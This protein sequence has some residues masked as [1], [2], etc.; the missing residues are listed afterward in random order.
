MNPVSIHQSVKLLSQV[1]D[2]SFFADD[3][4]LTAG[5]LNRLIQHLDYQDRATRAWLIGA[6]LLCGLTHEVEGA[7]LA[8]EPGC[9]LT[10][11]GDLLTIAA[12]LRFTHS[13]PFKDE[14]A[15]YQPLGKLAP[16]TE[17][18]TTKA[19]A[20]DSSA[21][22]LTAAALKNKVVALYLE[23]YAKEPEFC[24]G[25]NC[26]NK[27]PVQ[28]NNLRVLLLPKTITTLP[29]GLPEIAEALPKIEAARPKLTTGI[30]KLEGA[31]G[32]QAAFTSAISVTRSS[33]VE[34]LAPLTAN[35]SF[36]EAL[37]EAGFDKPLDWN[38]KLPGKTL[39]PAAE[40]TGLLHIHGFYREF[41]HAYNEWRDSLYCLRGVCA[42]DPEAFPK[43]VLLGVTGRTGRC[44]RDLFRH[45][46][47]RASTL[48]PC[49]DGLERARL[50][51]RR[52]MGLIDHFKQ[53]PVAPQIRF[54]PSAGC[55]RPLGE[56]ALPFYFG[57]KFT[58]PWN[59]EA[60]LRCAP[61]EPSSYHHNPHAAF[62]SDISCR[63]FY[64][65][66]GHLGR[67]LA[68]VETELK[69]LRG[70]FNLAFQ[71][72]SI[73]IE[74]DP[75]L[76]VRPPIRFLDIESLFHHHTLDL[77]L[78]LKDA[79]SFTEVIS[80]EA[81]K[82]PETSVSKEKAAA[83]SNA[84]G[85]LKLSIASTREKLPGT[86]AEFSKQANVTNFNLAITDTAQ[87]GV[88]VN[89]LAYDFAKYSPVT[90]TDRL[91]RPE[92]LSQFG[93][94]FDLL[95]NR[96]LKV[97][98]RSIFQ[99]FIEAN[100]GAEHL[101]GVPAGGT[102]VLVYSA[103]S[104]AN[105]R[106]VKA[107]FCLPYFSY[108]DLTTLEEEEPPADITIKPPPYVF[109]PKPWKDLFPWTFTPLTDIYV[110][111]KFGDLENFVVQSQVNLT[112]NLD[113]LINT[114]IVNGILPM[115]DVFKGTVPKADLGLVGNDFYRDVVNMIELNNLE[116]ERLHKEVDL[117]LATN[118]T[119]NRINELDVQKAELLGRATIMVADNM[120]KAQAS[121]QPV[122]S[123]ERAM[124]NVIKTNAVSLESD[125]ARETFKSGAAKAVDHH[126]D[127]A[128]VNTNFSS[129]VR[130][131]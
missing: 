81:G 128:A 86:F 121:G 87:K 28:H 5:Q 29:A 13:R 32:L 6:G 91:V 30:K 120:A 102:F 103:S 25:D 93:H 105:K 4:V 33:L 84:S 117:G 118:V 108:F 31:N 56:R 100:P 78:R 50:L 17:L 66:E 54:T 69:R 24:T 125:K 71:I 18:L 39:N 65:I 96:E 10:T 104:E 35:Q 21:K 46:F 76:V 109:E 80:R 113:S 114:K 79:E 2:F 19:A 47:L 52:L 27:G 43:H 58:A 82:A 22:P 90:P 15:K 12:A 122:A 77:K 49:H 111:K 61:D 38:V 53:N 64:R 75:D 119:K 94:L 101:G 57:D 55:H 115:T 74:D 126:Q 112:Q 97:R 36:H 67:T 99:K 92:A 63:P 124:A 83:V 129:L 106:L 110:N 41:T 88:Q 70:E 95:K 14:E 127:V 20:D 73:Q 116:M 130:L 8:L 72:L 7:T 26:D 45:P 1:R 123:A 59:V 23:S 62:G 37:S 34:A 42:P 51:W 68:E 131:F 3:Q 85:Q 98:Q 44:P 48:A 16:F 11:D 107:D 9:A 60:R 40:I 89:L